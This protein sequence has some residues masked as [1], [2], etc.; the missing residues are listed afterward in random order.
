VKPHTLYRFNVT[1]RI[2]NTTALTQFVREWGRERDR[3]RECVVV[4][5]KESSRVL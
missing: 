5:F 2:N 4:Y 1:T 3:E